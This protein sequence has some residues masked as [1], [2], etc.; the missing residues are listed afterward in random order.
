MI[1]DDALKTL[2]IVTM[3]ARFSIVATA[4]PVERASSVIFA[5]PGVVGTVH[6]AE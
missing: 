4:P 2:S 3:P 1:S 6:E 5:D